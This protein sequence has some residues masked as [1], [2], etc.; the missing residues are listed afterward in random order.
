NEAVEAGVYYSLMGVGVEGGEESIRN[1]ARAWMELGTAINDV[2]SVS[3]LSLAVSEPSTSLLLVALTI[4]GGVCG[5][6]TRRF[7][8]MRITR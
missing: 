8:E 1:L 5:C 4:I 7:P 6:I 2:E 3:G